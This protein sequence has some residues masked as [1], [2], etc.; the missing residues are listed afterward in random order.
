MLSANLRPCSNDN[1]NNTD[2]E[3]LFCT[4]RSLQEKNTKS[5][6]PAFIPFK[7]CNLFTR[8]LAFLFACQRHWAAGRRYQ[9]NNSCKDS[10]SPAQAYASLGYTSAILWATWLINVSHLWIKQST[11]LQHVETEFFSRWPWLLSTESSSG[12]LSQTAASIVPL[13]WLGPEI[14]TKLTH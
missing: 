11:K 5:F 7:W 13:R 3:Q 4:S 12:A 6:Q 14:S 2:P 1:N 8:H 10:T 9:P